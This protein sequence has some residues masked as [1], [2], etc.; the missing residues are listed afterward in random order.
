MMSLAI[1]IH[2]TQHNEMKSACATELHTY[3]SGGMAELTVITG[4]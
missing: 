4:S 1:I 3:N 2:T